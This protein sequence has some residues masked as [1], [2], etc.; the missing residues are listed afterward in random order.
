MKKWLRRL[1]GL[2]S[3]S[4]IILQNSV[5]TQKQLNDMNRQIHYLSS[6]E[7]NVV[8][9]EKIED[10]ISGF[11]INNELAGISFKSIDEEDFKNKLPKIFLN[12]ESQDTF[13]GTLSNIIGGTANTAI[14][15][16]A[17]Y[18]LFKATADPSTLMKLSSGGLASTVTGGGKITQQAGFIQQGS[19]MFTPMIVFQIAS[20]ATGQYYM[21]N[22]AKQ[23]NSV[24]E[25]LD[26]LLN[27]FHIERQAKLIKAFK[28][29]TE[30]LN[31]RNFVIE[32][33]VLLKSIISELTSVREEYF[34]MLEDSVS[35]IKKNNQYTSVNSLKEAKKKHID[36]EKTGFIF[37]M[38]T[39]LIADELFHLAKLTEFHMNLCY[40]NPDINRI[41][42]ISDQ[43]KSI[44]EFNSDNISFHKTQ[45]LYNEI[46]KD[47]L[48]WLDTAKN[49]T[50]FNEVEITEI[51]KNLD[52]QFKVFA[53]EKD[54][55]IKSITTTYKNVI[56]PFIEQRTIIIDNRRGKSELYME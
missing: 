9:S 49:N 5:D 17:T 18:G 8:L 2:D 12:K 35:E 43:L 48:G 6:S 27:L 29:L 15:S 44:N 47:T 25:K 21:N 45:T 32:D 11:E 40:K 46:E 28:F 10:I 42:V 22:I 13:S 30:Y 4:E 36:F 39:S 33:F 7:N 38:K 34:L 19:T 20:I 50:W 26:E 41:N 54:E 14:A 3:I 52:N 53:S 51:R 24:Q 23:L 55:K 1:L 31:K 56:N 16:S 37:K